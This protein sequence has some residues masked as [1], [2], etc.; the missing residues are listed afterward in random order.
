MLINCDKW[1]NESDLMGGEGGG[2]YLTRC[3]CAAVLFRM[4]FVLII[5]VFLEL[6]HS[7]CCCRWCVSFPCIS[8]PI[9]ATRPRL[10][11]LGGHVVYGQ[12]FWEMDSSLLTAPRM[13]NSVY[14]LQ[15]LLSPFQ[16]RCVL[17]LRK[18][19]FKWFSTLC[20]NYVVCF[21]T[22]THNQPS[23]AK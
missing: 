2:F 21:L 20:T 9:I 8:F 23:A 1:L 19:L 22:P 16:S 5:S 3:A 4:N 10:P 12:E 7:W 18:P 6:V 15:L 11:S 17:L 13:C 14:H